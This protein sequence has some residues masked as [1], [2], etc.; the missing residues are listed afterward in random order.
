MTFSHS[1]LEEAKVEITTI[2]SAAAVAPSGE[3]PQRSVTCGVDDID[4]RQREGFDPVVHLSA[5]EI[6]RRRRYV[7]G[8]AIKTET[9]YKGL[10]RQLLLG[11]LPD[12]GK[13][14]RIRR[15]G[16]VNNPTRGLLFI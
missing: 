13:P 6:E 15:A 3:R 11:T 16:L 4:E 8:N 5:P 10:R 1:P 2:V 7:T 9:R 12:G 14:S